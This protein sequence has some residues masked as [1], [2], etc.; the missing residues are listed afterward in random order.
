MQLP[1]P[2]ATDSSPKGPTLTNASPTTAAIATA[3]VSWIN[4]Q[5]RGE[6]ERR[7]LEQIALANRK[8]DRTAAMNSYLFAGVS[9]ISLALMGAFS[10]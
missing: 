9:M 10:S 1:S 8:A 6:L 4:E 3:Y 5:L 7:H 2:A